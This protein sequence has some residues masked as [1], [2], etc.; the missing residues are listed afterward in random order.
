[1]RA[2]VLKS[3][4]VLALGAAL[5]SRPSTANADMNATMSLCNEPLPADCKAHPSEDWVII[6]NALCPTWEV[7]VCFESGNLVCVADQT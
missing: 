2:V 1:M 6:C 4:L 3:I 5:L 7:A